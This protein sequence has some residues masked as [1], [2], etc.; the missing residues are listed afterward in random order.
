MNRARLRWLYCLVRAAWWKTLQSLHS[1]M[2]DHMSHLR[3]RVHWHPGRC[4]EGS[5]RVNRVLPSIRRCKHRNP[6]QPWI[7]NHGAHALWQV[8]HREASYT[9]ARDL[10]LAKWA[11]SR[12]SRHHD[13]HLQNIVSRAQLQMDVPKWT[14][15]A[16]LRRFLLHA[17][18]LSHHLYAFWR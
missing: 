10:L 2:V 5:L 18:N 13:I 14:Q 4:E 3:F 7:E 17:L 16:I 1:Q 6:I 11:S 12:K 9:F 8:A 15:Q